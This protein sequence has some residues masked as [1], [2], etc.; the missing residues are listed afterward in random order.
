MALTLN[1]DVRIEGDRD[2]LKRIPERLRNPRPLMRKIGVLGMSSAV[3]RLPDV[4]KQGGDVARTGRLAKSIRVGAAGNDGPDTIFELSEARVEV[5]TNLEYAAQVQFGGIIEPREARALAIPLT[6]R[7]KLAGLGPRGVDPTGE[8]LR[9]QPYRGSK[10][11][12]F[13]LLIDDGKELT[14]RQRKKRGQTKYGP[15]PLFALAWRVRQE[16]RPFLFW[17]DEDQREI[18]RLYYEHVGL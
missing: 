12:V 1:I 17:D 15:G 10:P 2:V 3:G 16:A 8:L 18:D 6:K 4:L 11:D 13:G 7:L 9:F 5:G 14:G